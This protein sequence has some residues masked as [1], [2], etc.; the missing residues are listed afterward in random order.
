MSTAN[1]SIPLFCIPC[2]NLN[3]TADGIQ[4]GKSQ[5]TRPPCSSVNLTESEKSSRLSACFGNRI[6]SVYMNKKHMFAKERCIDF[7]VNGPAS[8][9]IVGFLAH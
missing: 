5:M 8:C 6:R 1:K 2:K 3:S 4:I 7:D 9:D